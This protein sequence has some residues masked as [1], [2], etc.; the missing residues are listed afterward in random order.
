MKI[1]KKQLKRIIK[2]EKAKLM[3]MPMGERFSHGI[4]NG[5]YL[6][7]ILVGEIE[8]Y[9]QTQEDQS[10]PGILTR[11]EIDKMREALMFALENIREDYS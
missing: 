3:E 6:Y 2:E 1:T 10:A 4:F 8:D 9:L 7:D 5:N 11:S